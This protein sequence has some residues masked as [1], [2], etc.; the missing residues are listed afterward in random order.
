MPVAQPFHAAH[1]SLQELGP[2]SVRNVVEE[3]STIRLVLADDGG[4]SILV[5][6]S[7]DTVVGDGV[8]VTHVLGIGVYSLFLAVVPMHHGSVVDEYQVFTLPHFQYGG[9]MQ[10]V[11]NL[12]F[13]ELVGE[14]CGMFPVVMEQ[15]SVVHV[16]PCGRVAV[17]AE[18]LHVADV[19]AAWSDQFWYVVAEFPAVGVINEKMVVV[20]HPYQS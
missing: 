11:V 10:V 5:H 14:L 16:K 18:I 12:L 13:C 4:L 2:T 1:T 8:S 6:E 17:H 7:I 9:H 15:T 20:A 19:L 3:K